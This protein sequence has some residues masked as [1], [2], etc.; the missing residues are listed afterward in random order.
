M[1][2]VYKYLLTFLFIFVLIISLTFLFNDSISET[3]IVSYSKNINE[4]TDGIT[5]TELSNLYVVNYE[6]NLSFSSS[7]SAS[8]TCLS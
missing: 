7:S 6:G 3:S 2:K 1:K 4:D 8:S 5:S